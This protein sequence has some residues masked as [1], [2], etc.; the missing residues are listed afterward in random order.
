MKHIFRGK[1]RLVLTIVICLLFVVVALSNAMG[2]SLVNGELIEESKEIVDNSINNKQLSI[3]LFNFRILNR[4]WNYWSNSP[5]LFTIPSGNVG[6][7]TDNPQATLDIYD[8]DEPT[9]LRLASGLSGGSCSINF[10]NGGWI[11]RSGLAAPPQTLSFRYG[12]TDVL[13]LHGSRVGIGI[14]NPGEEFVVN[15]DKETRIFINSPFES[16]PGFE[17]GSEGHEKWAIYRPANTHDLRIHNT[18]SAGDIVTFQNSTG[19]VGIGTI[20]P[21]SKLDIE[22]DLEVTG[23]YKGNIGPGNGAPFPRPAYDSGFISIS[24]GDYKTLYHNISGEVMNYV[25]D[26]QFYSSFNGIHNV[27]YGGTYDGPDD[28]GG[29]WCNLT[30]ESIQ[31]FRLAQDDDVETARIR[32][33]VYN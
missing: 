27:F 2:K 15:S 25:V 13:S 18:L 28:Q 30:N 19:N 1:N 10:A 17:F 8:Y 7:G 16:G 32:I 21:D 14:S 3:N 29:F 33:W 22:G 12:G 4:D 31:I 24:R 23:A 11:L 20:N 26:L 6:I 5:N 9:E